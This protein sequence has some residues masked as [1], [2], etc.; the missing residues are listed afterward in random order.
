M[1]NNWTRKA[2]NCYVFHSYLLHIRN[3]TLHYVYIHLH[4][5]C[6]D[7]PHLHPLLLGLNKGNS[8]NL[9][10]RG[11]S[12]ESTILLR[13]PSSFWHATVRLHSSK[14]LF[15]PS[16]AGVAERWGSC[17]KE[18]HLHPGSWVSLKTLNPCR[19]HVP[20]IHPFPSR[21][22]SQLIPQCQCCLQAA[23]RGD[24]Q[25]TMETC[26][27]LSTLPLSPTALPWKLPVQNQCR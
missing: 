15:N 12:F 13:S 24:I 23:G 11:D 6:C 7:V 22:Q 26:L 18:N 10:L 9:P 27:A 14:G 4:Y 19:G 8:F 1:E 20:A 3:V 25:E 16:Q 2:T 17:P 5:I 21:Q